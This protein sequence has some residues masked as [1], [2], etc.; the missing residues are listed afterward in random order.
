MSRFKNRKEAG[1]KLAA[2][3]QMYAHRPDVIVLGLPRGGIPVAFEV[4]RK[5]GL[6]LDVFVVRK[7]GAPGRE[8]LAMGAIASGGIRVFNDDVVRMLN[9]SGNAIES[10]AEREGEE[11]ERREKAYRDN[12][13]PINVK[14]KSIIIVD[15]GLATG[16]TMRA[17]VLALRKQGP[18]AIIVAVPAGSPDACEKV[19][20]EADGIICAI[21]PEP[22]F[23]VGAWYDDFSQTTD[24]EIRQLLKMAH[25]P[26]TGE[27]PS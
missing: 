16:A 21:A 14:D 20:E 7:L 1:Q 9:I 24:E 5:L 8:E 10:A 19:G 26:D 4:A 11:L 3:L 12:L 6:P 2:K 22:F 23:A 18:L 27:R 17:A 15:D 13:P 25:E